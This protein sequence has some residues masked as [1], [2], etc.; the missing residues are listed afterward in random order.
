MAW[1]P[2]EI[3]WVSYELSF[4]AKNKKN[5]QEQKKIMISSLLLLNGKW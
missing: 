2:L 5:I 3:A 4:A 1:D